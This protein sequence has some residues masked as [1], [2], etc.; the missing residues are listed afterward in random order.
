MSFDG[1]SPRANPKN[2]WE[3]PLTLDALRKANLGCVLVPT[4]IRTVNDNEL[5]AMINFAVNNSDVV[6]AVNFQPV[7]LVG[8]M[9]ARQRETQR[10]TIPGAI[11]LIEEQT[12]GVI[13]KEH[14][15]SVPCVGEHKQVR[16]GAHR[17]VQVRPFDALRVRRRM[18]SVH[19]SRRQD[20]ADHR[21]PRRRGADGAPAEHGRRDG[22]QEQ[23]REEDDSSK[24]ALR[25]RQV[26]RQE[27]AAEELELR[28]DARVSCSPSTTSRR[29]ASYR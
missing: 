12:N 13:R 18:L 2:H 21:V 23:A 14:W 16:R 17:R 9:P 7:S 25:H 5:G 4:V 19:R 3:I 10:I 28:E 1:V 26:H 11:K 24:G 6:R 20:N 22:R 8:R 27:E 29:W 15:F